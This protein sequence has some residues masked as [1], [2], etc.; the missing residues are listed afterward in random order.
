MLFP[1]KFKLRSQDLREIYHDA[2]QFY[3][4]NVNTWL[5]KDLT[6]GVNAKFIEIGVNEAVDID[7]PEDW[8]IAEYIMKYRNSL[9]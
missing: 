3:V 4:A 9:T 8:D 2:G 5:T 7:N 6:F 1:E